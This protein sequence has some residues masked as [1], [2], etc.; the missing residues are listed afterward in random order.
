MQ[1]P[2]QELEEHIGNFNR[3][4]LIVETVRLLQDTALKLEGITRKGSLV[5]DHMTLVAFSLHKHYDAVL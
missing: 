2:L 1:Q 5:R 4:Y 3:H